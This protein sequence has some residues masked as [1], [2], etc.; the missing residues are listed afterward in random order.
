MVRSKNSHREKVDR[1]P[2]FARLRREDPFRS[3]DDREWKEAADRIAGA[4]GWYATAGWAAED[5]GCRLIRFATPA[6]AEDMQRWID[7]SG[8]ERRPAPE[9]YS[10]PLLGVG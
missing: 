4:T 3:V 10:G 5:V 8:I 6:E 2:Y 7:E 9:Q 1:L